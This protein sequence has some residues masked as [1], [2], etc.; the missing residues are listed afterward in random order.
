M[1][2]AVIS[3]GRLEI[4]PRTCDIQRQSARELKRLM[5]KHNQLW[6]WFT[7]WAWMWA[8]AVVCLITALAFDSRTLFGH[9]ATNH[10]RLRFVAVGVSA[11]LVTPWVVVV[12]DGWRARTRKYARLVDENLD[13]ARRA[14]QGRPPV[15]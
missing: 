1:R 14:N 3:W 11:L 4:L 7:L 5:R 12:I 8:T 15:E 10:P 9:W 13:A 6:L 2:R